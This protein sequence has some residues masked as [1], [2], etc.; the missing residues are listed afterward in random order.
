MHNP[1]LKIN[2]M[3]PSAVP[4]GGEIGRFMTQFQQFRNNFRGDA[5]AEVQRLLN[6]GEMTQEQF[7]QL[8]SLAQ[9]LNF[10]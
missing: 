9:Q 3:N 1:L 2:G 10:K 8:H 6:S 7:N 4:Q 5:K